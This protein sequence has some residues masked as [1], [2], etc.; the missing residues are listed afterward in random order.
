M[1]GSKETHVHIP[2]GMGK[3]WGMGHHNLMYK[4]NAVSALQKWM[5]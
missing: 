3:L 4:E 1:G 5:N 2:S